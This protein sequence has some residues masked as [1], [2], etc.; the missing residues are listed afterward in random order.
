[1]NELLKKA[2]KDLVEHE[3]HCSF[4]N[5]RIL[6][7]GEINKCSVGQSMEDGI[8]LNTDSEDLE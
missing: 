2:I 7:N 5:G 1:M 3:R 8:L 4:C 6:L